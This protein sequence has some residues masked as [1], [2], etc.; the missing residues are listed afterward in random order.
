MKKSVKIALLVS[1]CLLL[2]G[3]VIF[4]ITVL[5]MGGDFNKAA[6]VKYEQKSQEIEQ[7]F[8]GISIEGGSEEVRIVSTENEK[9]RV[10]Y[11]QS[12]KVG[13]SVSV[14]EG[15]LTIAEWDNR[16]WYDKIGLY[17]GSLTTL[18]VYLPQSEYGNLHISMESGDVYVA[19]GFTFSSA[20]LCLYSGDVTMSANILNEA[21]VKVDSGDIDLNNI[22]AKS[23]TVRNSSG[24]LEM[25]NVHVTEKISLTSSSGEME[26]EDV[27]CNILSI[28]VSSGSV[29]MKSVVSIAATE[30]QAKSGDIELRRCDAGSYD[31]KTSSGSVTGSV[32]TEKIFFAESGSG[33]IRVPQTY[34]G[35][36]FKVKTS[37]GDISLQIQ[38]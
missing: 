33:R 35:G 17:L 34:E 3:G 8:S 9:C 10:E 24:E 28:G 29:E 7:V 20:D 21:S 25:H 23:I 36:V 14:E 4:G 15:V 30:I 19:R 38:G 27:T 16:K 11:M 37:S 5:A 2:L 13:Y 32:L 31:I 1:L 26:L 18:T 6:T 22:T 12:K